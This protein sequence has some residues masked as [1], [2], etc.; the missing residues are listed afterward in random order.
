MNRSILIVICDF[1]VLSAMS[2][3]IGVGETASSPGGGTVISRTAAQDAHIEQMHRELKKRAQIQSEKAQAE[4]ELEKLRAQLAQLAGDVDS[5]T[6]K[7]NETSKALL[8][9]R[10]TLREKEKTLKS[11]DEELAR[12]N[13]A[14]KQALANIRDVSAK[15]ENASAELRHSRAETASRTAELKESKANLAAVS[16]KLKT[17]EGRLRETEMGLSY[18]KG[19]LS[20]TEKELAEAKIKEEA[21]TKALYTRGVEL[22]Q[23]RVELANTKRLLDAAVRNAGKTQEELRRMRKDL[24]DSNSSLAKT[25]ETLSRVTAE[26]RARAENLAETRRRLA[27]T[28]KLLRSEALEK[29]SAAAMQLTFRLKN[30]PW[31][32]GKCPEELFEKIMRA[33]S[34]L[35][36]HGQHQASCF[37]YE[38]LSR[39]A[40]GPFQTANDQIEQ[41]KRKMEKEFS[42]PDFSILKEARRIGVHRS[43]L[44]RLFVSRTGMSPQNYLIACRLREALVRLHAGEPL[45][46]IA[47]E[48]GFSDQNYFTRVFRKKYGI[49]PAK[50]RRSC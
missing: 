37:A 17:A 12:Q 39:I 15:Y 46:T 11:R 9:A 13:E 38:L 2:L 18:A 10:M 4:S 23:T 43:T 24:A 8:A 36:I 7:L 27:E 3:S 22:E 48:C 25:R 14:L 49:P 21:S 29:Y 6:M 40:N 5:R 16:G 32:A 31:T 42:R 41:L 30:E 50:F 34:D 1:L 20:R 33:L 45:K 26:S 47:F 19:S 44:Y 35:G 28:E